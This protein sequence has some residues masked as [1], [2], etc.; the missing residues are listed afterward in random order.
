GPWGGLRLALA[1]N[2]TLFTLGS[3]QYLP[4][5]TPWQTWFVNTAFRVG[6]KRNLAAGLEGRLYP[7]EASTHAAAYFYF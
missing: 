6:L 4:G 7:N 1:E 5:Q 3:W 2:V